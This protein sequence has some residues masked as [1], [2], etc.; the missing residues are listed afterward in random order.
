[1]LN[2]IKHQKATLIWA[3]VIFI[4][5]S[6]HPPT[7]TKTVHFFDGFDKIVHL[8]LFFVLTVLMFNGR[9]NQINSYQYT[10]TTLLKIAFYAILY[11]II[12][13][14][15]QWQLFTYR[16]ADWWDFFADSTGVA[17]AIFAYLFTHKKVDFISQPKLNH[18]KI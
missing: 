14:L 13:E 16:G 10:L 12:I 5:C 8:G 7:T 4:L 18:E 17:M 9:T 11:G 1:M 2:T 3:I 15:M 6:M